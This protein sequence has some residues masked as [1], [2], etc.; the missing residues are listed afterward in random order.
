MRSSRS[1]KN[2]YLDEVNVYGA[3]NL[4]N[5]AALTLFHSS[6]LQLGMMNFD[7]F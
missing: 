2:E 5:R 6:Q 3:S 4:S 7:G 1:S